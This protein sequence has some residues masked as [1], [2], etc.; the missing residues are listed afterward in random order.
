MNKLAREA[1]WLS[2]FIIWAAACAVP[3][4]TV[5]PAPDE[6]SAIRARGRIV[7]ALEIA[8][9][10]QSELIPGASRPAGTNCQPAEYIAEELR[11]FDVDVTV[12]IARQLGVEPCFVAP[13]WTQIIGGSWA[14]RWDISTDSV[15]VTPDRMQVLY[16]TQPYYVTPAAFFVHKDNVTFARVSDL[17]G[18]RIGVCAGCT[19]EAY[20]NGTLA[21]HGQ[22]IDFLV[23]NPLIAGYTTDN[24]ALQDL[25]L[26]DGA[27]LDAVLTALPLGQSLQQQGLPIK[28][29]GEPVFAEYVGVAVDKKSSRD[30]MTL[31]KRISEIIQALHA[32]GTLLKLSRQ[33]YA[34]DLTTAASRFDVRALGQLP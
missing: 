7:V 8:F 16:F 13:Q 24:P 1:A 23:K 34:Q 15:T 27:R 19:Y 4:A 14:D 10:P 31:V 33:Y 17:S 26:G 5:L 22:K 6:L 21:L 11:G 12:E 30:P 18:K 3:P 2:A 32:N 25:A 28:L 20:L 9:A 29:L